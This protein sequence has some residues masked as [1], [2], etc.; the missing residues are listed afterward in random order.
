MLPFHLLTSLEIN[1]RTVLST[2]THRELNIFWSKC[3]I[4][5]EVLNTYYRPKP[6]APPGYYYMGPSKKQ[7]IEGIIEEID[8]QGSLGVLI[9]VLD[10]TIKYGETITSDEAQQA[11][12]TL[13]N[14]KMGIQKREVGLKESKEEVRQKVKSEPKKATR[15]KDLSEL[16]QHYLALLKDS[17]PQKRGYELEKLLYELFSLFKLSPNKPFKV[18]GEQID[19]SFELEGTDFLIEAQWEKIKP[20]AEELYGFQG[21]VI[22]KLQGTKGLFVSIEGF[23]LTSLQAFEKGTTPNILLMDGEDLLYVLEE[24]IDLVKL[25][26]EK[27]KHAARTGNIF[28]K[29]RFI[30]GET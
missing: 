13:K 18:I 11:V 27:R 2:C 3:N 17:D 20:T 28:Y 5:S 14:V 21:K 30:L 24:R 4:P 25:L 29:V 15:E 1:L 8:K 16:R 6:K 9:R 22:R 7:I 19:G 26:S 12:N 10:E 23:T